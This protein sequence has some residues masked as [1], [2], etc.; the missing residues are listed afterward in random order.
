VI[1]AE[2]EISGLDAALERADDEIGSAVTRALE[3]A[4]EEGADRARTTTAF[5]DRTGALRQSIE[6]GTRGA[7]MGGTLEGHVA[8]RARHASYVNDG[9]APHTIRP[10]SKNLIGKTS[11]GRRLRFEVGG[12]TVYA[13]EVKHPGTQATNFVTESIAP[14]EVMARIDDAVQDAVRKVGL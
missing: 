8:A 7:F 2:L 4:M 9:T 11:R 10:N 1:I 12:R 3:E 6:S 5:K 14:D 13:R